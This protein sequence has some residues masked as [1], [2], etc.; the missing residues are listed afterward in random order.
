[1]SVDIWIPAQ[2]GPYLLR[3][4]VA[5]FYSGVGRMK[6]G[7]SIRQAQSDLEAV[8]KSLAEQFPKTDQGWSAAVGDL[9]DFRVG[10]YSRPLVFLFG[11]V[12]LLLLIA[13]SNVASLV[14]SQ[15]H[16]RERELAIRA[17]LGATR[18]QVVA[19]VM[20]EIVC[21]ALAAAACGYALTSLS[22]NLLAKLF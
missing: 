15:L 22:M 17:S 6:P 8:Q 2:L 10:D 3:L 13:I 21:I 14:L 11:A 12:T 16:E 1:G 9:K 5:R 18:T 20:R 7:V 4:R 19:S